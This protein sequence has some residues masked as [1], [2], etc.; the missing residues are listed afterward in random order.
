MS[1]FFGQGFAKISLMFGRTLRLVLDLP[2]PDENEFFPMPLYVFA[3]KDGTRFLQVAR[4]AFI[5]NWR[6]MD[7]KYPHF[8]D[9][10]KPVFDELYSKFLDFIEKE[11][12]AE[13]PSIEAC[14]LAYRNLIKPCE[15]W[16]SLE[17]ISNVLPSLNMLK[18]SS[19]NT[20]PSFLS[21]SMVL[22]WNLI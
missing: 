8:Y 10:I 14:E 16:S 11:V 1:A 22:M 15:V 12:K 3:T 6:R 4:N 17:D 19:S 13:E 9:H 20:E 2:P 21:V 7:A 18:L 5:M